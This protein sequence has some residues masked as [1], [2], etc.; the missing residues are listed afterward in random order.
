MANISTINTKTPVQIASINSRLKA[1]IASVNGV[2]LVSSSTITAKFNNSPYIL[3]SNEF[4]LNQYDQVVFTGRQAG[5]ILTLNI[6]CYGYPESNIDGIVFYWSKNS[7][8]VWTQLANYYAGGS[9][10]FGL[11]GIDYDDIIRI[12]CD[13]TGSAFDAFGEGLVVITGGVITT[14]SG[15]V[16]AVS[17]TNFNTVFGII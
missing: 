6:S 4:R 12:R 16:S 8:T 3:D 9:G 2:L 7:E 1:G 5:D 11:T 10:S 15:S 14:G 17:P 13:I